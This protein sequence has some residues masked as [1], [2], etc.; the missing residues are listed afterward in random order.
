MATGSYE[1]KSFT[2]GAA[3]TTVAAPVSTTD[4]SITVATGTGSSY[5]TGSSGPFVIVINRNTATEEKLLITSRTADVLTVETRGYDDGTA[6]THSIGE[7]IEH[8][9]DA[10]TV[11]QANR[12][13]N[14][15]T[16]KGEIVAHDGTNANAVNVGT[17]GDVLAADSTADNGVVWTNRLT[18]AESEIDTLQS[19]VTALQ[20][21]DI[22]VTLTGHVSGTGTSTNLGDV[23]FTTTVADDSH[24]H[25]IDNVDG[26][27]T[28]LD[29]KQPTGNYLTTA[30]TFGGDVTGTYDAI[31]IVDD[32]HNHTIANIDSLSTTLAGKSDTTH[33]HTGMLTTSTTFGG[34]VTGL[35]NNLQIGAAKVGNTEFRD[36][37]GLSV[38]GRSASTAGD[39]ADIVAGTD[40]YVLRRSG[41]TIG[42][43]TIGSTALASNAV[44][45]SKIGSDAV[46]S[47]KIAND[48]ID[49]EHYVDASIDEVHLSNSLAS[50]NVGTL[51]NGWSGQIYYWKIGNMVFGNLRVTSGSSASSTTMFTLP[52]GYRPSPAA[53]FAMAGS[54]GEIYISEGGLIQTTT[55]YG[56]LEGFFGFV[57]NY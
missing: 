35:Y 27:Q 33:G 16:A 1:R 37:T 31:Q 44:T 6:F 36:S 12:Y 32:S 14:L 15:Q 57:A 5:P 55:G 21:T 13:V 18:T 38:V 17:D 41:S 52:S 28:A 53:R 23:S 47:A 10:S 45:N 40:G 22:V 7:T 51:T 30:T 50:E 19:D 9:L 49:S 20:G 43:G 25:I 8:I 46:T 42:F 26:L 48:S 29:G 34:D 3:P 24:N 11:D 2:G 39:V 56:Y 54:P 4:T